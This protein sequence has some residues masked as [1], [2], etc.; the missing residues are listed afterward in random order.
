M[1]SA[2]GA[3]VL[4]EKSSRMRRIAILGVTALALWI[5]LGLVL[6][7]EL[8]FNND[9]N[10]YLGGAAALRVGHGYRLEQ[11][12]GLPRIGIYPPGFSIWLAMFWKEGQPFAVNSYRLVV[13]NW[14]AAGCALFALAACLLVSELPLWV[15]AAFLALFGTS[16]IFTQ[17]TAWLMADVLFMAGSCVLALLVAAYNPQGKVSA[18]WIAAGLLTGALYLIKIAAIAY[19]IGLGAFGLLKGDLRRFSRFVYFALPTF[20]VIVLWF[21]FTRDVPTYG[22]Q[23][24]ARLSAMKSW[25]EYPLRAL[26]QAGLYYSGRWLVEAML[27]IPD[28]LSGA[29]P[30]LRISFAAEALAFLLGF[31]F[32]VPI[33]LGIRKGAKHPREQIT[34]FILGAVA[35]QLLVWPFYLG[36]RGGIVVLPFL[37]NWLSRGINSKAAKA[38][39]LSLL[40]VNIPGNVWLSYKTL[41]DEETKS[42]QSLAAL[43]QAASWINETG[44]VSASVAA[45]R[46]VPLIHLHEYLGRRVLAHAAPIGGGRSSDVRHNAQSGQWP[47]YVIT[48]RSFDPWR[49]DPTRYL[50]HRV[51]GKWTVA[52][53]RREAFGQARP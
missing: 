22:T 17:L 27:N 23:F 20:S 8:P 48:D 19:I 18:W 47:D 36:A 40:V 49:W 28:R 38:A 26:K 21:L 46:D 43:R 12:I 3:I 14:I 33:F 9:Q 34:L 32:A 5:L 15:S 44:G 10:S 39:F 6:P 7:A 31:V 2:A 41:L 11:Y 13:A 37:I 53:P 29:R 50:V 45:G 42:T 4:L 1:E 52:T 25:T 16:V 24:T 51:F 35:I 30:F